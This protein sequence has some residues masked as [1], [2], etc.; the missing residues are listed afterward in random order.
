M[1]VKV[2]V[3]VAGSAGAQG[4]RP[5]P[6]GNVGCGKPADRCEVEGAWCLGLNFGVGSGL[7]SS[8]DD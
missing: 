1:P 3:G 2:V 7:R 4:V 5:D 6:A 8:P